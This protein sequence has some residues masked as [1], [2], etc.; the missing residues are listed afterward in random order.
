MAR[1]VNHFDYQDKLISKNEK[2]SRTKSSSSG[3]LEDRE[4]ASLSIA[5]QE[6]LYA[7]RAKANY[8]PPTPVTASIRFS[9]RL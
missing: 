9:G 5:E 6:E 8:R 2:L 7:A 4:L 3:S 1:H